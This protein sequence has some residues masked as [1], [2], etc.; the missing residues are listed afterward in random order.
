MLGACNLPSAPA[1]EPPL[2]DPQIRDEYLT[3]ARVVQYDPLN[4]LLNWNFREETGA[5]TDGTFELR[6]TAHWQSSFWP[7]QQFIE[8]QGLVIRFQVQ[9]SSARSEFVFVTGDWQTDSFRQ[10]G[11]YNAVIPKGDLFQG[12]SDLGG[13]DLNGSF[14]MLSNTWYY[15]LLAIGH[16]RHFLALV[17]NPDDQAE[18]TAYDVLSPPSWAGRSWVFLP[19]ATAGETLYVDDFYRIAFGDI[20]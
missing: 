3:G 18:R 10:F 19:K 15:L 13:Y 5:L 2:P 16:N 4:N 12:V 9:H 8:G 17:W 1:S 20:K 14:H 11:I 6:G 7:K